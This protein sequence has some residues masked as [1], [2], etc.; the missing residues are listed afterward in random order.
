MFLIRFLL[1]SILLFP[2][3]FKTWGQQKKID[4]LQKVLEKYKKE[5]TIK[6]QIMHTLGMK[7]I[8][9]TPRKTFLL[10]KELEVLGKKLNHFSSIFGS[11][12]LEGAYYLATFKLDSAVITY[13]KMKAFGKAHNNTTPIFSANSNL[14]NIA[15]LKGK[16]NE[17]IAFYKELLTYTDANENIASNKGKIMTN[18]ANAYNAKG[19]RMMALETALKALEINTKYAD[20]NAISA[21]N[22]LIGSL[23]GTSSQFG[24]AL[25]YHQGYVEVQ[26]RLGNWSNICSGLIAIA[27]DYKQLKKTNKA[28]EY[29][30]KAE[31]IAKDYELVALQNKIATNLSS[32]LQIVQFKEVEIDKLLALKTY[33]EKLG[34]TQEIA[35]ILMKLA[36]TYNDVSTTYLSKKGLDKKAVDTLCIGFLKRATAIGAAT[37]NFAIKEEALR[38]TSVY[39]EQKE[40][41]AKAF[42]YY[43]QYIVL[44]DSAINESKQVEINKLVLQHAFNKKE[45]SLKLIQA[46]TNAD[47]QKQFFLN[48]QQQQNILLQEKELLINRQTILNN[49]QNLSLLN[50]DKVLQHLAYL[51]SQAD[52][53]TEQLLKAEKEGQ[54]TLAQKETLLKSA[55]LNSLNKENELNI[56]KRKQLLGYSI[57]ALATLLFGGLYWYNRSK[58]K[59]VQLKAALVKEKAEKQ[60]KEAEF[61]KSITEVSLSALQS[62]MNPHFIFN[63]LNSIKLYTAQ[64][65]TEAATNYL[66]KFSKLIRMALENSRTNTIDLQTELQSL[67]LYIQLEAMRFK[68]KLQYQITIDENVAT[69]FIEIPPMLIQ[70]YVEN[71]IWHGLMHKENGGK[72][73]IGIKNNATNDALIITIKDDGVGRA[74]AAALSNKKVTNHKS[75][76][77]KVTSERLSLINELYKTEASVF[78]EDVLENNTI[79]GTLVTIKIPFE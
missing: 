42:S 18:L 36:V 16:P 34:M 2:S 45:D 50:K 23:Y 78:I 21:T 67:E 8:F 59:E 32:F 56:S 62:Q 37:G 15:L 38:T 4:S 3:F 52:L 44:K 64:N 76:G 70:P 47:L 24:E 22:Y 20:E 14:A 33:Y 30:I 54:L 69:D 29:Y 63:C 61:Q 79:S 58:N 28:L 6:A 10:S 57:A 48:Q 12:E 5:D 7:Y 27:N 49:Q 65:D 25:K 72:V 40:D 66:T 31:K 68:G 74:M 41:F 17:A 51:K 77:T 55:K 9:I 73:A 39:Y 53:Q 35:Q 71:A 60:I 19:D 46:N 11:I 13:E 26:T 43:Q 75:I 1:L